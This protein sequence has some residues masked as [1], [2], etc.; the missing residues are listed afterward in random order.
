MIPTSSEEAAAWREQWIMN[1]QRR[2]RIEVPAL[3][4]SARAQRLQSF[5]GTTEIGATVAAPITPIPE[6]VGLPETGGIPR[7]P[8]ET[9]MISAVRLLTPAI[10]VRETSELVGI[11]VR[12]FFARHGWLPSKCLLNPMRMLTIEHPDFF[13]LDDECAEL[14]CYTISIGLS[15]SLASDE[16]YLL[17]RGMNATLREDYAL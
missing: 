2:A 16:V 4:R 12:R 15:S 9:A 5:A 3:M 13:P 17:A 10:A 14:G 6:V 11:A 8:R 7:L 1:I